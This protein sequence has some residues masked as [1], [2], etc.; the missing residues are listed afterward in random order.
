MVANPDQTTGSAKGFDPSTV[1]RADVQPLKRLFKAN[2]AAAQT[3]LEASQA[4]LAARRAL[5]PKIEIPPELP[6]A[7]KAQEISAALQANQVVVVAG[8]TGS[9]KT[10][11]LPKICLQAGFGYRGLIGHTQPRR[12]A[13]RAVASRIAEELDVPVGEQVGYSVRF[14]DH[15]GPNSL[16]KI[17]TDG[18]LLAEIPRDRW[19]NRYDVIIVDEAHERSLNIDFLLGYLR[20][21]LDRRPDLKLI[22]T[23]ATIDV[24][25]FSKHF[26]DAPI[27]QVSGRGFPVAIDYRDP[28]EEDLSPVEAV[29]KALD[30]IASMRDTSSARD[31]LVF[32][33]G[34]RDIVDLA[35]H[36]RRNL[37]SSWEVL[38]LYAR[39]PSSEQQRIFRSGS[40]RRVILATNVAETSLTVPNIGY[41]VDTGTA[42][43][44]RYSYRSKLQRL[45]IEPISQAS[46]AQRAGRCGRLGPGR[47]IRLFGEADFISRPEFTDA[48]IQRTNLASVVLQ[49]QAFGLGDIDRFPFLEPPEPAAVRAAVRLLEELGALERNK[50]TTLGRNMARL[51]IDPRLARVLLEAAQ[52]G[53]LSELLVIASGLASVDPRERPR[54][55]QAAADAAHEQFGNAK[56]EFLS[57]IALWRWADELRE[58]KT[59]R[60]YERALHQ[61]FVS[62]NRMREWRALYRQLLLAIR[63]MGLRINEKPADFAAIH[64]S[65]LSG[66]LSFIGL[67]DERGQYLGARGLRFRIFPGSTLSSSKPKW[68]MAGE[69]VE[70]SAVYARGI[71]HIDPRWVETQAQHL[72][73]RDYTEPHWSAKRGEAMAYEKVSLYGLV[74]TERRR[75]SYQSI[76]PV[77]CRELFLR[78]G[79][80]LGQLSDRARKQMGFLLHNEAIKQNLLQ[81]EAKARRRDLLLGEDDQLL[82]YASVVPNEINNLRALERWLRRDPHN[83]GRLRF[84]EA[85]LRVRSSPDLVDYPPTL[86]L[87]D[88]EYDLRYR[89]APG[90]P[91]DGVSL[92]VPLGQLTALVAEP[93][94]WSVPGMLPLLVEQWL[95]SLPKQIRKHLA[96][97]PDKL[98][99]LLDR[100]L[101]RSRYR[102]GRLHTALAQVVVDLYEVNISP[103]DWA[104][105]EIETHLHMNVKVLDESGKLLAQDRD[106]PALQAQF[107]A[108]VAAQVAAGV[109]DDYELEGLQS[110]PEDR[111]VPQLKA[112]SSAVLAYP[113]LQDQ[114]GS[115]PSG[116]SA[117]P[118][119]A[120][121]KL[122]LF[123]TA[124]EAR[125]ANRRGYPRLALLQ[126][127]TIVRKLRSELIA[128]KAL[129]L[130]YA[131]L[132]NL[133]QLLDDMLLG[134]AWHTLFEG[135]AD[136]SEALPTDADGF[137]ERLA[138][139]QGPWARNFRDTMDLVAQILRARFELVAL[140]NKM[141]SPA[142]VAAATDA[143][144]QLQDLVP[145]SL[146][147][148]TPSRYLREVPRYLAALR[149]RLENLQGR[150]GRDAELMAVVR[151]FEARL[152][153]LAGLVAVPR[154]QVD[155]LRF[156]IHELR[157]AL[158]AER[159]K[160]GKISP[161]RL[162]QRFLAVEQ[163]FGLA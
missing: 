33:P 21:L 62:P 140:L 51:P 44:S 1:L 132:G 81:Q 75:V 122:A 137:A 146:V 12:I 162:Q 50:V 25:A 24:E 52:Q 41:V 131:P 154:E 19:L 104:D 22:I 149:Y 120:G 49:M 55:K 106:L 68:L 95:R 7:A 134:V 60:R 28:A 76:D 11:Q 156:E 31:A 29:T 136:D 61:A 63:P 151:G 72:L 13:A 27:I 111:D 147:Q 83:D 36:L 64:L 85:Q 135:P 8:E 108:Q 26:N 37:K 94:A 89:F 113:G 127:K 48:E 80:V 143:Q 35:Q 163:E 74:L 157:V 158:F 121:V 145:A 138:A 119:A 123:A 70:T 115:P 3:K 125:Q 10:T 45:P 53:A 79:L 110:F 116:S 38:P 114:G 93:L 100:L 96:P 6:I 56:S 155:S 124:A 39:L 67:H 101:S 90:E 54:D 84:S 18:L 98:P 43:I 117:G 139:R 58:N 129:G 86:T 14:A 107:H 78:D 109:D 133:E 40:Q 112:L 105:A 128:N 87:G 32:L 42:R 103:K 5:A 161:K 57:W 142:F 2:P 152:V 69:I 118:A 88:R 102:Q 17:M 16:I 77:L 30:D 160:Q 126:S 141:T 150:V 46:A 4:K 82:L 153:K 71:A 144:A 65:L 159:L 130:H 99:A 148:Q 9:G 23:S 92:S 15:V 91:D 20:E 66:S 34:E 47:C 97:L 73:K 59:K